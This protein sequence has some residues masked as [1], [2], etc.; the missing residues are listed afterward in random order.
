MGNG[1][2]IVGRML[3]KDIEDD[4]LFLGLGLKYI[5]GVNSSVESLTRT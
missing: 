3:Y 1:E 2:G 4:Y 5:P